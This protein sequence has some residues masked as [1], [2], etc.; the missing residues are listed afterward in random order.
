MKDLMRSLAVLMATKPR[1]CSIDR[2]RAVMTM[3]SKQH[4]GHFIGIVERIWKGKG[5]KLR[6]TAP[7]KSAV[8]VYGSRHP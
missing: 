6:A 5:Y 8:P 3:T 2:M 4:R 7:D 1:G